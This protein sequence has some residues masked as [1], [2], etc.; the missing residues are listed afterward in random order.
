MAVINGT[1]SVDIA[2]SSI[3]ITVPIFAENGSV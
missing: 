1:V 2:I 3:G